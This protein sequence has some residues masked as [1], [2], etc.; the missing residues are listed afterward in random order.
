MKRPFDEIIGN[1][2]ESIATYEYYVDFDKVYRN[3][4]KIE[5]QL[6]LLNYLIGK[7]NIE[8]EFLKLIMEYPDVIEVIPILLAIREGKIK[9]IDDG[10]ISYDFKNMNLEPKEYVK[11]LRESGLIDLF[12][13]KKI[14]NLVDY[15]TGVEVGL[16]TNARKNRTGS[17]MENIVEKYILKLENVDYLKEATKEDIKEH[18]KLE[19]IEKLNLNEGKKTNKRFDFVV[20]AYSGDLLLIETNFYKGGGSKLNETARSYTKLA[21]DLE[22]IKG[23]KFIWITDGVGWNTTKNNLKEAYN[24]I[25]HLYTLEDLDAGVLE[26]L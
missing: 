3:V 23:V 16:D 2:R 19:E 4:N 12:E 9:I 7:D 18:F 21:Q 17:L 8:E 10:L 26:R 15:V 25:E 20:R 6:N 1:L 5:M 14:K 11:L 22:E 24:S 13:N